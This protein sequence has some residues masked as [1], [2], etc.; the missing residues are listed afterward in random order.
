MALIVYTIA[1][2]LTGF[3]ILLYTIIPIIYK[4]ILQIK[5]SALVFGCEWSA[6]GKW[7]VNVRNRR[8]DLRV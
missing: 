2:F 5:L 1:T 7:V 3:L 8:N 6:G 4:C